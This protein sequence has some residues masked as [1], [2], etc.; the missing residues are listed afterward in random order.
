MQAWAV[1]IGAMALV[2]LMLA[3][4]PANIAAQSVTGDGCRDSLPISVG[5]SS[6]NACIKPGSGESFKVLPGVS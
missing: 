2:A 6:A 5:Q 1:R 4:A 3:T